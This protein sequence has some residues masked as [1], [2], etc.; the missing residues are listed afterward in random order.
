[1]VTREADWF[2][3]QCLEVDVAS[4][5][6]SG[7]EA[8]LNLREALELFNTDPVATDTPYFTQIEVRTCAALAIPVP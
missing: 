7:D 8:L 2:V 6:E 3:A 4:Q 5:G 1:V